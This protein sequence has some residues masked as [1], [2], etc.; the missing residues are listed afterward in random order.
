MREVASRLE[1]LLFV[2]G[3]PVELKALASAAN[4]PEHVAREGL[5]E[6]HRRLTDSGLQVVELAGGHQLS[7]KPQYADMLA[8]FLN[9]RK[10]RFSRAILETLAVVAYRQPITLAEIEAARGVNS[11]YSVRTLT[12]LN[13]VEAVGRKESAGRPILYGTTGEFLHQFNLN[14]LEDLPA[15]E[16]MEAGVP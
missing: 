1:C 13:L 6:L 3:E 16:E 12:E 11:D 4:V 8:N 7:T 14:A 5:L 2:A 9:P 10:R 15:L